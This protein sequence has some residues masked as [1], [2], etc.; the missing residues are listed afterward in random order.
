[1]FGIQR[2]NLEAGVKQK[3]SSQ[4]SEAKGLILLLAEQ[5]GGSPRWN[6]TQQPAAYQLVPVKGKKGYA[7]PLGQGQTATRSHPMSRASSNSSWRFLS[8]TKKPHFGL[9]NKYHTATI[10]RL[11]LGWAVPDFLC[12]PSLLSN[13]YPGEEMINF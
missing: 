7:I 13:R 4:K 2:V 8:F 6:P 11:Y 1:M 12:F 9:L 5:R 10:W 3:G